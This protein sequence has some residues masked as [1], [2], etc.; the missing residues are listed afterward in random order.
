MKY[1]EEEI[2]TACLKLGLSKAMAAS[3]IDNLPTKRS[4]K[5]NSS[6]HVLFANIA[7]ELNRLGIEFSYTGIKGI[8]IQTTYTAEIVKQFVWKPLASAL[9]SKS[10]TTELT[11]NDIEMIFEILGRWFAEKDV[12]IEFPSVESMRIKT[13]K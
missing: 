4:A 13:L 3:L 8:N 9:L 7:Y 10:S 12:V 2:R 6:I 1:D 11:H 5:E